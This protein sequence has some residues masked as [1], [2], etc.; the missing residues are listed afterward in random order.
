[1]ERVQSIHPIVFPSF[2]F[3]T[4]RVCDIF[5]R[6][7]LARPREDLLWTA[8][9]KKIKN[10]I[11]CTYKYSVYIIYSVYIVHVYIIS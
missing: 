9:W 5:F 3:Q 4:I 10:Y 11:F 2:S 1:M 8:E 6:I 7:Q